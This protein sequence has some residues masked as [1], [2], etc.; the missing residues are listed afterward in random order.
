MLCKLAFM[1]CYKVKQLVNNCSISYKSSSYKSSILKITHGHL[2]TNT[3]HQHKQDKLITKA[4]SSPTLFGDE[5][6]VY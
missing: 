4:C 5:D 3:G 1:E 2:A 6:T